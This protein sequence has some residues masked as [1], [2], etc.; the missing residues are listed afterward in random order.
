MNFDLAP[1][2]ES[3]SP[4]ASPRCH[5]V[6][7]APADLD[8]HQIP[9]ELGETPVKLFIGGIGF[10]VKS[11]QEP[12][13]QSPVPPSATLAPAVAACPGALSVSFKNTSSQ[14]RFT[15]VPSYLRPT[16]AAQARS[17]VRKYE[18]VWALIP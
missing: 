4:P 15:E 12:I 3:Q 17:R 1:P 16:A 13:K 9:V 6:N 5:G 8:I 10:A 11:G 2:A 14:Q 7:G 18:D